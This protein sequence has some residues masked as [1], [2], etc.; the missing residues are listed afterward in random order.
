MVIKEICMNFH[1]SASIRFSAVYKSKVHITLEMTIRMRF[2]LNSQHISCTI[3]T[4]A[5]LSVSLADNKNFSKI[6]YSKI[7]IDWLE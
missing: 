1:A 4:I 7:C 5:V 2:T 3:S 6:A